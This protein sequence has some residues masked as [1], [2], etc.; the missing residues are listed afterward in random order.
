MR[1]DLRC[2]IDPSRPCGACLAPSPDQCPYSYL[3]DPDERA[4]LAAERDARAGGVPEKV[5]R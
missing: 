2:V 1:R 3:L 4:A 5:P